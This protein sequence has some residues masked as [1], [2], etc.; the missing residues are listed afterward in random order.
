MRS[1]VTVVALFPWSFLVCSNSFETSEYTENWGLGAINAAGAYENGNSGSGVTI[2]I[3]DTG[4]AVT[5]SEFKD[6]YSFGYDYVDDTSVASDPH[7]HGTHVA[8]IAAAARDG[9]GM[10]GVAY[11]ASLANG[12]G[13]NAAGDGTFAS[14][15]NSIN[16]LA[17]GG[18]RVVNNSWGSSSAITTTSKS[19]WTVLYSSYV[20]K[21]SAALENDSL[22]VFAAGNDARSEVSSTSGLPYLFPE[23]E[24]KWITVASSNNSNGLSW[25][26]NQCGVAS[27]FCVTAPGSSIK[28]ARISGGYITESGTS[29]AAPMV[30]GVAAL[31]MEAFP[32]LTA[33]Q[34]KNILLTTATD[35]GDPG[36]DTVYGWG[37][38]DATKAVQG[39]QTF[40]S[41]SIAINDNA[42]SHWSNDIGG[43]GGFIKNG[44]GTLTLSGENTYAGETTINA[45][46]LLLNGSITSHV[47]VASLAKLSG[48][49]LING[50][51]QMSGTLAPGESPGTLTVSGSLALAAGSITVMDIDG[52]DLGS[53]AGS[54]DRI[55]VTG[56]EGVFNADGIVQPV[57]RG[58]SGDANNDFTPVI[59]QSFPII[60]AVG[61]ITN[62]FTSLTQPSVGLSSNS[63][64]DLIY[65]STV[66]DLVATP[67]SYETFINGGT[68]Q[69]A[70]IL[71]LANALDTARSDAGVKLSGDNK[72]FFD[73]LYPLNTSKL[74]E[75]LE[76]L[77]GTIQASLFAENIHLQHGLVKQVNSQAHISH[78]KSSVSGP[79]R[80]WQVTSASYGE[81]EGDVDGFGYDFNRY[82]AL[83][84]ID[85]DIN[86]NVSFGF[87]GGYA[88]SSITEYAE[89]KDG[90][91]KS[92]IGF[93]KAAVAYNKLSGAATVGVS[94]SDHHASRLITFGSNTSIQSESDDTGVFAGFDLSFAHAIKKILL[95]P[96]LALS[97][98]TLSRDAFNEVGEHPGILSFLKSDI[99]SVRGRL[100]VP[101]KTVLTIRKK[102]DLTLNGEIGWLHELAADSI[103]PEA[104]ILGQKFQV[105]AVKPV[106]NLFHLSANAGFSPS[107]ATHISAGYRGEFGRNYESH[108]FQASAYFYF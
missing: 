101:I 28:S 103:R 75:A 85:V 32:Y 10:H 89:K 93:I 4:I 37:L 50:D 12:R 82:T 5:H 35:L 27:S 38:I 1:L 51:V 102:N 69:P 41:G 99:V 57:L 14:L 16:Y 98:A 15:G 107:V 44:T 23:W 67:D 81:H 70:I 11:N 20:N 53:G 94:L 24:A 21:I 65:G 46:T 52:A 74:N 62:S 68:D 40:S 71:N 6:K 55:H 17:Q 45:G 47:T 42:N 31:V 60:S 78:R 79:R 100:S 26:S 73:A 25:F 105:S 3:V 2:G 86:P 95:K 39:F 104:T 63:R 106:K 13:L 80:L 72:T 18:A 7:G 19:Y 48:S 108:G 97:L 96:T 58:I 64:F 49:G 22:L 29:M 8:G 90:S 54:H 59:G 91:L 56:A 66:I 33:E 83:A 88:H 36:V 77:T 61:G 34:V 76:S 43:L 92:Y 30:S 9:I 84:G 87:G